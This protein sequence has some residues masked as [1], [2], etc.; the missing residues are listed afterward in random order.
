VTL[1]VAVPAFGPTGFGP[2]VPGHKG[3]RSRAGETASSLEVRSREL[4]K[5]VVRS[6]PRPA[7]LV[8]QHH[9][10]PLRVDV[11][12]RLV[13]LRQEVILGHALLEHKVALDIR[14]RP[15]RAGAVDA[16]G[17]RDTVCE[18]GDGH[19]DGGGVEV[20]DGQSDLGCLK[21]G[22]VRGEG[23][24]FGVSSVLESDDG[25]F[26]G[27]LREGFELLLGDSAVEVLGQHR[28]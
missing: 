22:C 1:T 5:V 17:R 3:H 14:T 4:A 13:R 11:D 15:D 8:E 18:V 10:A 20:S 25:L 7:V 26:E 2:P 12:V 23:D 6:D 28:C 9:S 24:V 27:F 16:C 19:A 21:G